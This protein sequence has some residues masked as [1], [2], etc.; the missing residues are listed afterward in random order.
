M[1][2]ITKSKLKRRELKKKISDVEKK[3]EEQINSTLVLQHESN[4]YFFEQ[5]KQ[6]SA[7]SSVHNAKNHKF[8]RWNWLELVK[9]FEIFLLT[10]SSMHP[11][12]LPTKDS[13]FLEAN[14]ASSKLFNE[15][16]KL[17]KLI[18]KVLKKSFEES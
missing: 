13:L 16:H 4:I 8:F 18:K 12:F 6:S 14:L 7:Y 9:L 5:Q 17:A 10:S 1:S 15:N 2:A 3:L 11:R